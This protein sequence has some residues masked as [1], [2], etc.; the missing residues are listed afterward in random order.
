[1]TAQSSTSK[2]LNA[3]GYARPMAIAAGLLVGLLAAPAQLLADE[4]PA[5]DRTRM[6]I[7]RVICEKSRQGEH[8]HAVFGIEDAAF[9][10]SSV[11]RRQRRRNVGAL[12]GHECGEGPVTTLELRGHELVELLL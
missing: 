6:V 4:K 7:R 11:D 2:K 10:V 8:A 5:L 1:M 9:Q 12:R 3:R